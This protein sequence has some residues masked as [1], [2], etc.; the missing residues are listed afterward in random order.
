[1]TLGFSPED[2]HQTP[3]LDVLSRSV[4]SDS[5]RPQGL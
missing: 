5:L 1:M 2:L 3:D 4:I